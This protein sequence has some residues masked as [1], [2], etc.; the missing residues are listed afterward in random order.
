MNYSK[1]FFSKNTILR[2]LQFEEFK[3]QI[4]KGLCIEFGASEKLQKNFLNINN[5]NYKSFFSN[6]KQNSKNIIAIDL[7]KKIEIKKLKKKYHNVIILNVLE[8]LKTIDTPLVN[9]NY[10]LKEKG[11]IIGST[12]FIYRIHGAPNDYYR[13]TKDALIHNLKK[14]GFI[15]IKIKSLGL[16]PFLASFSLLRGYLKFLPFIYELLLLLSICLDFFIIKILKTNVSNLF[17]LGFFF[18]ATKNKNIK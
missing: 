5:N 8:H 3:K 14:N 9:I 15:N 1:F 17:P 7:E 2:D 12:P 11:K 10:L 4:L 16:G 18:I 6:L 13:F